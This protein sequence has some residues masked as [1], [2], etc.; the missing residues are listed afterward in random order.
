MMMSSKLFVKN[1]F[2][3]SLLDVYEGTRKNTLKSPEREGE[4][5]L[6]EV[7]Q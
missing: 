7:A 4:A 2:K 3:G 1:R 6:K 5:R